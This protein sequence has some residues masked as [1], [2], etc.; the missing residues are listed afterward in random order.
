MPQNSRNHKRVLSL[1]FVVVVIQHTGDLLGR[2][3]GLLSYRMRGS[4][5]QKLVY[6]WW[7]TQRGVFM[8]R[9]RR[10]RSTEHPRCGAESRVRWGEALRGRQARVMAQAFV[11]RHVN[12]CLC[13]SSCFLPSSTVKHQRLYVSLSSF[14][15]LSSLNIT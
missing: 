2:G 5:N 11:R 6:K 9:G 13:I 4:V 8:G 14:L 7:V 10:P 12:L 15:A 1:V 3:E